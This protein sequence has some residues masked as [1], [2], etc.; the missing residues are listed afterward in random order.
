MTTTGQL[1]I[2]ASIVASLTAYMAYVGSTSGW[3]YFLT[4]EECLRDRPTLINQPVRV[5]GKVM[6]GSL[7]IIPGQQQANFKIGK[8]GSALT[9]RYTGPLPDNLAEGVDVVVEGRLDQTGHLNG[10]KVLTQCASKY[11]SEENPSAPV[12][13]E[14]SREGRG[15]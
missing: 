2:A 7:E 6:T 14:R 8:A 13:A 15:R 5:S 9:V 12:P 11:A 1:G 4:V 10:D 3:Q